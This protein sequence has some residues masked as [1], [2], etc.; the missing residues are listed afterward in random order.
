ME[1]PTELF[2]SLFRHLE[3]DELERAMMIAWAIWRGRNNIVW[4]DKRDTPSR[5]VFAAM[6]TLVAW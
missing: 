6:T 2:L 3:E 1:G 5:Q 4:S